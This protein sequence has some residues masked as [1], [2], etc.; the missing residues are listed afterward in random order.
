MDPNLPP[1]DC[2]TDRLKQIL[3]NLTDNALRFSPQGGVIRIAA[4]DLHPWIVISVQDQGP[5]I[6]EEDQAVIWNRFER[7]QHQPKSDRSG[8]GLGLAIVQSLVQ[9]Y[10]GEVGLVSEVGKGAQFTVRLLK[11]KKETV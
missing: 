4:E 8:S 6:P 7:G 11:Y 1:V 2:G 3:L 5:G 9:A 10:N